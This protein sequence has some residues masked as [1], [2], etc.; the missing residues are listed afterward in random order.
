MTD[1]PLVGPFIKANLW[2][3]AGEIAV[4]SPSYPKDAPLLMIG[5]RYAEMNGKVYIPPPPK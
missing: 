2:G 4:L 5:E 3:G 1:D